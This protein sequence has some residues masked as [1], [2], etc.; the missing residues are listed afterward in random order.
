MKQFLFFIF[1]NALGAMLYA[2]TSG[3]LTVSAT[4][5]SAGGGYSPKNIV[6]VWIADESGNF[7]KTLLAY[8]NAQKTHLNTWQAATSD[9]GTEFNV[10]DAITG[11]TQS[12]HATRE[13]TWDATDYEGN[14]V[15]DGTYY[16]WMELTDKNSTGNYSS[17]AFTKGE[18]A[19]TLTPEDVPSF[20]AISI[21]WAPESPSSIGEIH[22]D[23]I[24]IYPN[25]G[26]GIYT[27]SGAEIS[28]MEVINICGKV[29]YTTYNQT[30]DIRSH[31][32]GIYI[33][34]IESDKGTIIRKLI[35]Q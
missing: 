8:A 33:L 2:Q 19:E 29:I 26:A 15:A 7:V 3:E 24:A 28:Q 21:D 1:F 9:A 4:T 12:A 16:V 31:S 25:P 11:A 17:F 35:K 27:V 20:A 34:K 14:P 22:Q 23:G 13:C 5:S 30:I 32:N 10:V 6:A 18:N